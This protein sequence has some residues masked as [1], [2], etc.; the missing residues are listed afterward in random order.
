M[1]TFEEEINEI[2]EDMKQ[3]KSENRLWFNTKELAIYLGVSVALI[4]MWR[5]EGF[6]PQYSNLGKRKIVYLKKDIA[7]FIVLSK[8]KT[9]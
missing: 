6:E 8:V 3:I 4:E 2:I 9:M 5:R 1:N 7:S